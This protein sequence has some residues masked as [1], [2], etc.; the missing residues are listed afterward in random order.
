MASL[1]EEVEREVF[2]E[3]LSACS[4]IAGE[5]CCSPGA[6]GSVKQTLM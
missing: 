1:A 4:G 5:T 3:N 6:P 2:S